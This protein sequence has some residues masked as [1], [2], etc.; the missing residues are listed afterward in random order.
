MKLEWTSLKTINRV[1]KRADPLG[2]CT[3][4]SYGHSMLSNARGFVSFKAS[5]ALSCFK[6]HNKGKQGTQRFENNQKIFFNQGIISTVN[7]QFLLN[8]I[9]QQ[10]N[11][12]MTFF[13]K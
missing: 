13:I 5:M 12:A 4:F 11:M 1:L 6:N 7:K 10:Q 8:P 9:L 2:L 3:P